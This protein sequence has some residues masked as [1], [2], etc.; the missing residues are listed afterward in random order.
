MSSNELDD[1]DDLFESISPTKQPTHPATAAAPASSTQQIEDELFEILNTPNDAMATPSHASTGVPSFED[2]SDF[3]SW[4]EESPS[5]AA[6]AGGSS[7]KQSSADEDSASEVVA[8]QIHAVTDEQI[9]AVQAALSEV[10]PP[11]VITTSSALSER[12]DSPAANPND[13]F[14]QDVFGSERTP[15]RS[16]VVHHAS[17]ASQ[18]SYVSNLEAILTSPFPDVGQLRG[19]VDEAGYLPGHLRAQVLLLLLTGSSLLDEEAQRYTSTTEEHFYPELCSDCTTLLQSVDDLSVD[20]ERVALDMKDIIIL[21]C[22]RRNLEYKNDFARILFSV[23]GTKHAVPKAVSS[24]LFY[25]LASS[26]MPLI[27]LQVSLVLC[28]VHRLH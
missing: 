28:I 6:A 17:S 4:L 7:A 15:P 10:K 18:P 11:P 24:G 25:S 9:T 21:Y 3:L 14:F 26:F 20:R 8:P 5:K 22:Q 27:G 13:S 19:L 23:I 16:P 12:S 1:L 2:T